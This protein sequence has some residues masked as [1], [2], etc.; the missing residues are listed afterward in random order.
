[1]IGSSQ[2]TMLS[3]PPDV[4]RA[5][6]ELEGRAYAD[7]AADGR[8]HGEHRERNPHRRRRLVREDGAVRVVAVAR[9]LVWVVPVVYVVASTVNALGLADRRGFERVRRA[10][11]LFGAVVRAVADRRRRCG[12]RR[13]PVGVSLRVRLVGL[14]S[15]AYF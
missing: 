9:G 12:V 7:E 14:A 8:E 11:A 13:L 1:M 6:Y 2:L 15:G 5:G 10:D 4:L 3:L